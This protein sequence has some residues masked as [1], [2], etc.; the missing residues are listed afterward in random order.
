MQVRI[1]RKAFGAT[2]PVV[3]SD[4]EFDVGAG[5][6]V[7]IIGPSGA[8]KSTLLSMIAGLDADYDGDIVRF[9]KDDAS[10]R[11]AFTDIAFVFQEPRLM[12]WLSARDNVALVLQHEDPQR[13]THMLNTVGLGDYADYYPGQLSGGMQRRLALIRAFIVNPKLLLL[14]E[15]FVSLDAPTAD[16]LRDQL[17]TLWT[18]T[19]P[20]VLFVT[21]HLDEALA[22]ADRIIFLST[23]PATI[24]HQRRIDIPRPRR[25]GDENVVHLRTEILTE[26]PVLLEGRL[27]K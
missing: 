14:D 5:E 9:D 26:F 1:K 10:D 2:G 8:G 17:L 22:I 12:P 13:V 11:A 27:T 19:Q 6:I 7:S 23:G 24:I 18:D 25:S 20:S 3:I 16:Q 15:P 21:H 4:L